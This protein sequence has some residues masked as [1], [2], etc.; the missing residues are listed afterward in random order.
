M[1]GCSFGRTLIG[2]LCNNDAHLYND[3]LLFPDGS[4][5][6]A[7]R[8]P[9][10]FHLRAP[11]AETAWLP[12][13]IHRTCTQSHKVS[14]AAE[15]HSGQSCIDKDRVSYVPELVDPNLVLQAVRDERI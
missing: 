4:V 15:M 14:P 3:L 5:A 7:Q 8:S 2:L 11:S 1:Y 13:R 12:A 9:D 10:P 6:S